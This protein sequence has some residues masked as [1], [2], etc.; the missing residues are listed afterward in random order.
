MMYLPNVLSYLQ[1][2]QSQGRLC[3]RG[4]RSW[5]EMDEENRDDILPWEKRTAEWPEVGGVKS[6][7]D[8]VSGPR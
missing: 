3:G 4:K 8:D 6:S 2:N 5:V 1:K 7:L